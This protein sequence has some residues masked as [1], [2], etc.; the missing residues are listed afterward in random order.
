LI[1]SLADSSP[2]V[3]SWP[4]LDAILKLGP[5]AASAAVPTLVKLLEDDDQ[6]AHLQVFRALKEI[7]PAAS[8][9]L[10]A[11]KVYLNGNS[12]SRARDMAIRQ[13]PMPGRP[14]PGRPMLGRPM[15]GMYQ[16]QEAEPCLHYE[17]AMAAIAIEGEAKPWVVDALVR[18]VTDPNEPFPVRSLAAREV[19][20]ADPLALA[21]FLPKM[22]E[23]LINEKNPQL[24]AQGFQF[25]MEIDP[26]A[27]RK[28]ISSDPTPER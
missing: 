8:A 22:I 4:A 23:Q 2:L 5:D 1:A 26:K 6:I 9:A 12:K 14:M 24:R 7:G 25:L 10:P 18:I 16:D 11:L 27:M 17:A 21:D 13:R 15:P 28:A 20:K 3:D 19:R